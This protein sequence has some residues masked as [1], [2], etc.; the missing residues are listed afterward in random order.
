[1]YLRRWRPISHDHRDDELVSKVEDDR[2]ETDGRGPGVG[3][4]YAEENGEGVCPERF[5]HEAAYAKSSTT[6][7]PHVLFVEL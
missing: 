1:M 6:E 5:H 7:E 3:G 4:E 2:E